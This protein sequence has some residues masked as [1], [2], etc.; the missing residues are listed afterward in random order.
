MRINSGLL[1]IIFFLF[2]AT[3]CA[4]EVPSTNKPKL[5]INPWPEDRAACTDHQGIWIPAVQGKINRA[6]HCNLPTSDA[7][8]EC[9]DSTQCQ[10]G[11]QTDQSVTRGTKTIG[12]CST[13]LDYDE[14]GCFFTVENGVASGGVCW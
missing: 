6:E 5:N 12:R 2:R 4:Q 10:G 9:N 3:A 14:K 13:Y 11:C 1:V 8:K 7:G